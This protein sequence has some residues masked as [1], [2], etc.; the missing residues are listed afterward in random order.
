M[1]KLKIN[2]G[3]AWVCIILLHVLGFAWYS[4]L[5]QAPW[6]EMVGLTMADAEAN[7]SGTGIWLSNT[8]A[9]IIPVY[10]MAWF[11]TK[12]NVESAFKGAGIG[13]LIGFSFIFLAEMVGNMFAMRPYGLA[14]ITGGFNMVALTLT[15]LILGAW[16]KYTSE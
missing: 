11:F 2:H 13:L 15:G 5:F 14:W 9:T 3:A 10:V 6:M 1:K 4:Y 16:R 7:P 12:L 8:I